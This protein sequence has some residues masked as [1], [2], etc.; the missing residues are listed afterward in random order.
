V[1]TFSGRVEARM[2]VPTGGAAISATVANGAGAQTVTVP[3]GNFYMTS[4]GGVSSLPTTLQ[5]QLNGTA[6][7]Q[8]FPRTAAATAS[9]NGYGTWTTGACWLMQEASGSLVAT[10]G[11]PTLTASGLTYQT[12]GSQSG[13]YAIGFSTTGAEADGGDV[14][15]VTG[16]DDVIVA[17][18]GKFTSTPGSTRGVISKLSTGAGWQVNFDSGSGL[19]YFQG[20]DSTPSTLFT[21]LGASIHSGSWH[22]GIA[23]I[24]RATGKARIGT[25]SLAGSSSVASE[26]STAATSMA[27]AVAFRVGERADNPANAPTEL[28]LSAVYVVSGSGVAAGLSANM[29]T[30]LTTFANAINAA[31]TVSMSTSTGLVS[32]GWTGYA[33]PTWSLSWSSTALRDVM[34]FTAN[35]TNVTT[36]QTGTQQ[37][38]GVWIPDCPLN[39]EG[40]PE[41]AP[42]VSDA[43]SSMSPTG[44]VI[45]LVG[46]TY[47]RHRN[48]HW[49]H[50]PIAQVWDGEATYENAS[51]EEFFAETQLGLNSSWFTPGSLIQIYYSNAGSD[52]L[53]GADATITGW[54]IIGITSIEPQKSVGDW[55]GLWRIE[56][57]QIVAAGS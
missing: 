3:A 38:R 26:V 1:P 19:Y 49:S 9:A 43:R 33:T 39:I 12:T 17:W 29:S 36:T 55:T 30:A 54:S 6:A 47:R 45:T 18:V 10:Y 2:T 40:D 7:L 23:T 50:V 57:P 48:V 16:T 20:L 13:D 53:L 37:A 14:F 25:R 35:I 24:D 31:W 52:A 27:N 46:N 56:L 32:I 44:Q 41:R 21:A 22:V 34:G 5:T 51:W 28:L 11:S 42:L 4:A 15:D 8:G